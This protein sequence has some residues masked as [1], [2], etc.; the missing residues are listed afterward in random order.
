MMQGDDAK[1]STL[2][3]LLANAIPTIDEE[4]GLYAASK[5]VTKGEAY[6]NL[7]AGMRNSM[8]D[9]GFMAYI[10]DKV[11]IDPYSSGDFFSDL[12]LWLD[13][14]LI[15]GSDTT[16][17]STMAQLLTDMAELVMNAPSEE[18]LYFIYEQYGFQGN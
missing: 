10:V 4:M 8:I 6:R 12:S 5:G 9:N 13:S 1:F 18:G 16:F 14:D 3:N 15:S 17:Y 2:Y 7:L 11:S